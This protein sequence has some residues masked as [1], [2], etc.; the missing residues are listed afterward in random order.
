MCIAEPILLKYHCFLLLLATVSTNLQ[1]GIDPTTEQEKKNNNLTMP[2][3]DFDFYS[4]DSATQSHILQTTP[5]LYP[6]GG[7]E[8]NF[9]NPP[10]GTATAAV[11]LVI[12]LSL[13]TVSIS[14]RVYVR[15]FCI[16]E[17]ALADCASSPIGSCPDSSSVSALT[18]STL[19]LLILGYV[20]SDKM[21]RRVVKLL[22][23]MCLRRPSSSSASAS[24]CKS[25]NVPASSSI[26]TMS[27]WETSSG[28]LK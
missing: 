24:H 14:A 7:Q 17:R 6:P 11:L 1:T 4:L 2:S 27:V 5:A 23:L 12:F 9:D 28:S 18:C 15:F 20:R 10:N 8:S 13:I 16:K 26:S 19:D 3:V 21:L 22:V 25:A